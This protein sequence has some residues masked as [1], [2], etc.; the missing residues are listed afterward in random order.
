MI[1]I[2]VSSYLNIDLSVIYLIPD[3]IHVFKHF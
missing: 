2:E 1:M 3:I